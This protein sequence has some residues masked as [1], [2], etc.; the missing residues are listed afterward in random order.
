MSAH[1]LRTALAATHLRR[2][3]QHRFPEFTGYCLDALELIPAGSTFATG[4]LPTRN[5]PASS[6]LSRRI[7]ESWQ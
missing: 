7:M 1:H 3:D 6:F 4:T 5:S 2:D